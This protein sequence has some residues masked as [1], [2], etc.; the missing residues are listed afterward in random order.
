ML[1][2]NIDRISTEEISGWVYSDRAPVAGEVVLAFEN[3]RCIGAGKVEVLREDLREAG[4]GDGMLGFRIALASGALSEPEAVHVRL[5]CSDFALLPGDFLPRIQ[6][7]KQVRQDL[8]SKEEL[9]RLDWMNRQGWLSQ[10]HYIALKSLNGTGL[11]VRTFSRAELQAQPI[12]PR[13]LDTVASTLSYLLRADISH[14]RLRTVRLESAQILEEV[15]Q[16]AEVV[17]LVGACKVTVAPLH[18]RIGASP[19]AGTGLTE[20]FPLGEHQVLLVRA[21]L[22]RNVVPQGHEPVKVLRLQETLAH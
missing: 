17:G 13:A 1:R 3:T 18:D 15:T 20:V 10:E 16:R 7:E 2:G 22:I 12:E 6:K 5:D 9:A 14:T 4:L 21:D 11:Y 19:A 8:F